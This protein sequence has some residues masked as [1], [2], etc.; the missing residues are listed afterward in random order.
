MAA[1]QTSLSISG[2][3]KTKRKGKLSE[4]EM[5]SI[6]MDSKDSDI[7]GSTDQLVVVAKHFQV[8]LQFLE[9]VEIAGSSW[10]FK[11]HVVAGRIGFTNVNL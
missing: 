5:K 6:K 9:T 11:K 10:R 8:F 4:K 3:R 1:S 2:E 7:P